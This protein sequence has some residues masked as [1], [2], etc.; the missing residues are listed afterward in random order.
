[1]VVLPVAASGVALTVPA[2][3]EVRKALREEPPAALSACVG[4]PEPTVHRLQTSLLGEFVE[5]GLDRRFLSIEKRPQHSGAEHGPEPFAIIPIADLQ[6][7]LTP[8]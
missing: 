1:M 3:L 8:D 2:M 6:Y 5:C 7:L 4:Q